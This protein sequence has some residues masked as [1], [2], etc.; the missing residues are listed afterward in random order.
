MTREKFNKGTTYRGIDRV[1]GTV[2]YPG[3]EI[4]SQS[5]GL[6]EQEEG[7]VIG[8]WRERKLYR[9]SCPT[10]V[11]ASRSSQTVASP[12]RVGWRIKCP[13]LPSL[14]ALLLALTSVQTT[15]D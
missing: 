5:L 13:T 15:E 6:R 4:T 11:V 8:S 7:K 12:P 9:E 1:Y 2:Q 10:G 14:S 3:L